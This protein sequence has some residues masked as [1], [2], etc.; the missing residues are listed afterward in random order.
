MLPDPLYCQTVREVKRL[1]PEIVC[2]TIVD[3]SRWYRVMTLRRGDD[4]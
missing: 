2:Q 3:G 1:D 4:G